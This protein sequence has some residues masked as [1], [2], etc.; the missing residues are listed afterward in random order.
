MVTIVEC[1]ANIHKYMNIKE[2]LMEKLQVEE[3]QILNL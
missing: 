1:D 3:V 2:S